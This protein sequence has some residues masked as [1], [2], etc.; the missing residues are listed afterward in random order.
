MPTLLADGSTG[1]QPLYV[2][3]G[4]EDEIPKMASQAYRKSRVEDAF[5]AGAGTPDAETRRCT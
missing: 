3:V 4:K 1:W 2:R 5:Q